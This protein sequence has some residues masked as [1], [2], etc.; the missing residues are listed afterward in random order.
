[1]NSEIY[2]VG[3][4]N[5]PVQDFIQV[6]Q[7]HQIDLLVDV[8]STPFSRWKPSYNTKTFK[9]TL[10]EQGIEYK[11]LGNKIGGLP[12]NKSL[13]TDD[14]PDYDKMRTTTVYQDGLKE[15]EAIIDSGIKAVIMCAEFDHK[16]CHRDQLI[17]Q[18][19][20][21]DG[22]KVKHILKDG[23]IDQCLTLF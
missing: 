23:N 20:I 2:T 21:K 13:Y 19:L 1:M 15:L 5:K 6:L 11:F 4:G 10:N 14:L 9:L 8:R 16:Q 3:Y 22:Y 18:N 17:S 7:K 12:K